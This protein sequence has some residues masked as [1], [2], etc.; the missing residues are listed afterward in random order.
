[1]KGKKIVSLSAALVLG[2][3]VLAGFAGCGTAVGDEDTRQKV[4]DAIKAVQP[5]RYATSAKQSIKNEKKEEKS[6]R[7]S[8]YETSTQLSCYRGEG[9]KV[10]A[11]YFAQTES[12]DEQT[13]PSLESS[14]RR[15]NFSMNFY[16]GDEAYSFGGYWKD[17][18]LK[19]GDYKGMARKL[20]EGGDYVLQTNTSGFSYGFGEGEFAGYATAIEALDGKV[21]KTGRGY[22]AEVDVVKGAKNLLVKMNSVVAA[23][24]KNADMTVREF[25]ADKSVK[26]L[27]GFSLKNES[28]SAGF[29]AL[30]QIISEETG[31]TLSSDSSY[32][33]GAE[34]GEDAFYACL[35]SKT[36]YGALAAT[37]PSEGKTAD[38]S[39][40]DGTVGGMKASS[41]LGSAAEVKE[42]LGKAAANPEKFLLEQL[43]DFENGERDTGA[44][45]MT[46]KVTLNGEFAV[47][48]V[49]TSINARTTEY[50]EPDED[51]EDAEKKKENYEKSEISSETTIK[52]LESDPA[53][54]DLTGMKVDM[55]KRIK[56]ATYTLTVKDVSISGRDSS[57]DSVSWTGDAV[58]TAT[59]T[60][61]GLSVTVKFT[62]G[63]VVLSDTRTYSYGSS[64]LSDYNYLFDG[65]RTVNGK[66]Y[67]LY[68]IS[69]HFSWYS[70]NDAG[71]ISLGSYT[72]VLKLPNEQVYKTL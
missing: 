65:A 55:G 35:E 50:E 10:F 64:S 45:K 16:R 59:V 32:Y 68:G 19:S 15:N 26:K 5:V 33:A 51:D 53:L 20:K 52:I 25:F 56:T 42:E 17:V 37:S 69:Y 49:T 28:A 4:F 46:T 38:I 1:M 8:S 61:T 34:N 70:Y 21:T 31:R 2:L 13:S 9:E 18:G 7:K 54:T 60:E 48:G 44:L 67:Y 58:C 6:M 40:K 71:E 62:A 29:T 30:A 66:E 41:L 36:L 3:G 14:Q 39:S 24:E 72:N 63:G 23:Y 47:T 11:D 27:I 57:Y 12:T 43:Y 22:E